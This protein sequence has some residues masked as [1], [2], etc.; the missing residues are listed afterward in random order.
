L[1]QWNFVYENREQLETFVRENELNGASS[2]LIQ[3]TTGKLDKRAL[4]ELHDRLRTTLP[5][6]VIIGMASALQFA[7]GAF[8]ENETVLTFTLFEKCRLSE[9][10]MPFPIPETFDPAAMAESL[11]SR[12]APDTRCILLFSNAVDADVESF[13][14]E[15][16]SR[17]SVPILGGLAASFDPDDPSPLVISTGRLFFND[18]VVAVF[19]SGETLF[20]KANTL[21]AWETIGREFTVTRAEGKK[22]YELDGMKIE[23]VYSKYFGELTKEKLLYLS[24][25]HPL[26][27]QSKEFGEM[28]RVLLEYVGEYGIYTGRFEEGEKVQIGFG[29]YRRMIE[30]VHESRET[31]KTTPTEA[32]WG[33]VCIS[34]TRGYLDLLEKSIVPYIKNA[35][36]IHLAV[37]FG[38]FGPARDGQNAFLNN[39]IIK[40]YLSED[41]EARFHIDPVEVRLD[42][43]DNLLETFSTLVTSSSREIIA[44][45]RHLEEEVK[46]RTEELAALNASLERRI[47]QEVQKNREKDKMLYHQSKLAAMGEMINNI[48]HQWRQPLNIIALVMQDLTLKAKMGVLEPSAVM[49]AEKKINDTLKYL[50]DTIDDFRSFASMG[51]D[52]AQPGRFKVNQTVREAIRLVSVVLEDVGIRLEL[53]LPESDCVVAGRANDLKQVILN[54]VYNAIDVLKEREVADP[55]IVI[56]VR[57]TPRSIVIYV[58]DNGGGID[59]GLEDKIFEP[60]FTTKYRARGTGLGLY[61]SKMIVEKRLGGEIGVV[62]RHGGAC[63]EVRLPILNCQDDR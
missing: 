11:A 44:L 32:F 42:E 28:T 40:V 62:R 56:G 55:Q 57:K 14:I 58:L 49:V 46:K 25:A 10:N 29:N 22:L 38:E 35:P 15:C 31:V 52:H 34:Y 13:I 2:L 17:I 39:T 18:A 53:D 4:E 37:T 19:V 24:L 5:K 12:M 27:R 30:C 20:L 48:A 41:A 33:F 23:E 51:E 26:V 6:A 3:I 7:E 54:L 43:K 63:F 45:N 50:S 1:K 8:Y 21:L 61:M 59:K 36:K 9:W 16:Q 60:Y 47:E